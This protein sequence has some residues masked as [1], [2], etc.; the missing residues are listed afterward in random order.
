LAKGIERQKVWL[1]MLTLHQIDFDPLI[2]QFEQFKTE[3]DFVDIARYLMAV[4]FEHGKSPA[5]KILLGKVEAK[6]L[7]RSFGS[8]KTVPI[9]RYNVN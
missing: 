5:K 4:E 6:E 7:Y 3:T 9:I 1:F 2:I 8:H